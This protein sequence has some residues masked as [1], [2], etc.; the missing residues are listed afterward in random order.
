[1]LITSAFTSASLVLASDSDVDTP[2]TI[3]HHTPEWRGLTNSDGSGLYHEILQRV[4]EAHDIQVEVDYFP[5]RRGVLN[6]S[7]GKADI[8][9]AINKPDEG[10][11]AAKNPI[12]ATRISALFHKRRL[13][14][15][16]GVKTIQRAAE[17]SVGAPGFAKLS[18][19]EIYEVATRDQAL[20]MMLGGRMDYYIDE[21]EF[22]AKLKADHEQALGFED[23]KPPSGTDS[24]QWDD[25]IIRP[26]NTTYAY[27]LFQDSE[28][29]RY[30]RDIY[31][32]R[33]EE[34]HQS[35]ELAEIYKKWELSTVMPRLD[36]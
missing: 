3:R 8:T 1:M 10:T 5:F 19:V 15:W 18:G 13:S 16:R 36:Q 11:I 9:G 30:F 4:Y 23:H 2:K 12:W 33:I 22:L 7:M 29:G 24:L 28:R 21:Y 32:K 6:V 27:M 31:D 25:F 26:V 20:N 35:G 17:R 14:N 34:L